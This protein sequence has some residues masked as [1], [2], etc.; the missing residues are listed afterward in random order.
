MHRELEAT[1]RKQ[2]D[3]FNPQQALE[4]DDFLAVEELYRKACEHPSQKNFIPIQLQLFF[5]DAFEKYSESNLTI[6][7]MQKLL[8]TIKEKIEGILDSLKEEEW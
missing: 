3:L 8:F 2:E 1:I 6:E 7:D 4:I 5:F